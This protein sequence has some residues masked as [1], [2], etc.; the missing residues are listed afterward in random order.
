MHHNSAYTLNYA[1]L[2]C[3]RLAGKIRGL[4]YLSVSYKKFENGIVDAYLSPSCSMLD[5][6]WFKV[7]NLGNE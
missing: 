3:F 6:L 2:W 4:T 5:V 7:Q 1:L